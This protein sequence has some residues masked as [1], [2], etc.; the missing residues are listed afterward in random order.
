M[1]GNEVA[2]RFDRAAA[3]YD[4]SAVPRW[5]AGQ[6]AQLAMASPAELVLDVATGTGLAIEAMISLGSKAS[7][8]GVDISSGMLAQAARKPLAARTVLRQADA[9]QL[10]FQDN[11][12]DL[13]ICVSAM[14][15][16][17]EPARALAEWRRVT[18]HGRIIFTAWTE[19]GL[20]LPRLVR[21]AAAEEGVIL[22]DPT[23]ALAT[24]DG[25]RLVTAA[26][27]LRVAHLSVVEH[28]QPL[29]QSDAAA[30]D[31][32]TAGEFGQ[33]MRQADQETQHRARARFLRLLT[34]A[35]AAE[36]SNRTSA[37]LIETAHA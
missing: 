4:D 31:R 14:P 35:T 23:A 18:R 12:F 3:T 27:G 32:V 25:L 8:T 34:D 19:G 11:M 17:R 33:P 1:K 13:T 9:N 10:P 16:F 20:T 37:Y 26:A 6:A 24:V 22:P 36:N 21:L 5:L 29:L 2:D 30:W 7:F 28:H 15:Y